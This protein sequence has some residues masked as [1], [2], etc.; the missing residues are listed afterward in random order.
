M[1]VI[2]NKAKAQADADTNKNEAQMTSLHENIK[3]QAQAYAGL[4]SNLGMTNA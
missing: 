1:D 4:K 3:N 2:I